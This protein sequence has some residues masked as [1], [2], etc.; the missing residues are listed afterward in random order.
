M[1]RDE[2]E[3]S[4]TTPS[5][6]LEIANGSTS[7]QGMQ[8]PPPPP[9]DGGY[10]WICVAAQFLINGFTWGVAAVRS[11]PSTMSL[12]P[13]PIKANFQTESVYLSHYLSHG[14]F[15]EARPLDYAFVGGF[16]FAFALLV[17]PLAT[18][19][20]RRYGARAPMLGGVV[21]LPAGFIAA[22]FA[23]SVWHLYL[24]Q[25]LCIGLGIGLVY[26]PAAAI[27]P[28]WFARR[29]SLAS[30]L[31]AAGSGVGGAGR[32]LCDAGHVRLHHPHVLA[33]RL[34]QGAARPVRPGRRHRPR[35]VEL[36]R[37]PRPAPYRVCERPPRE[38]RGRGCLDFGVRR[39]DLRAMAAVYGLSCARR[40]RHDK[41]CDSGHLL[42]CK[43][44]H[45]LLGYMFYDLMLT[46]DSPL[47]PSPRK[48]LG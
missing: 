1:P 4:S 30:G 44:H 39:A 23:R 41:W 17:A 2:K 16:N 7:T 33:L 26:I 46:Q 48:S 37:G 27:V 15:G 19:L 21:L 31:C 45:V 12:L 10:G 29:R 35:A 25:G 28:Q 3:D 34:R 18:S 6:Q 40:L 47:V 32:L 5:S 36:G 13:I 14:L 11:P 42:G 22:S 8:P 24:S 20:A 43:W 9:P 38:G